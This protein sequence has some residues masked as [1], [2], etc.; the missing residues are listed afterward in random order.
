MRI[1]PVDVERVLGKLSS[2]IKQEIIDANLKYKPLNGLERDN[3][4]LSVVN[5]LT[6]NDEVRAGAE[7]LVSWESGW[8]ENL[9]Q[10]RETGDILDLVPKYH[11]KYNIVHWNGDV[12]KA[13]TPM[14]DYTIHCILVDWV[15]EKYLSSVDYIFDFGCGP[16]DNLIR[17]RNFNKKAKLT[18]L[19]WTTTSQEIISEIRSKNVDRNIFGRNFD[20]YNPNY[21]I[22]VPKNSGFITIASLEQ[23]GTNFNPFLDFVMKKRPEVCVH[24]EPIG[25]LLDGTSLIDQL[26]IL[27]FKKRNYLDGFLTKLCGLRDQGKVD[28]IDARRSY[29]GSYYIEGHSVVVW[30]PI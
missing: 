9:I 24:I 18:G 3:Y 16:C 11:G 23:V 30:K 15:V 28:I 4:I 21:N 13:L 20:Y 8:S 17:M 1:Q 22:V 12:V 26:S 5:Y 2:T 27:Y 29:T 19:D 25:E 7:R 14:Y 10:F 6:G